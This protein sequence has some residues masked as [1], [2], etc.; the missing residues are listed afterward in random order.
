MDA[1]PH[2]R[3]E[4][5]E[6]VNEKRPRPG[7]GKNPPADPRAHGAGLQDS[8]AQARAAAADEIPGFDNRV[9]FKLQ[10]GTLPPEEIEK[11]FP[12]VE[13][14]SQEDAGQVLAFATAEAL[15]FFEARL[16]TLAAGGKPK[17][18]QVVYALQAFDR[19]TRE[20]RTG[21][22]LRLHGVP[23]APS[24]R[25]DIELWPIERRTER[26]RLLES[27]EAWLTSGNIRVLDRIDQPGLIMFRVEV[28]AA[29][30]GQLLN[31]RD[32]RS[33]DLPPRYGIDRELLGL[34]IATFPPIPAPPANAPLVAVLDSG[35]AGGHPLIG[36]ALADAQGFVLPER[37]HADDH[38][39]GTHVAGIALYGDVE[40]AARARAF[41]PQLRLLS[42]RILDE[43]AQ[44][45]PRFIENIV[46]QAV[47]YFHGEYG[48]RIFNL[49]YGDANKPYLGGR[50]R[51]LA[52]TID[53]LSR[54]LGVLF[55]VPTGNFNDIVDGE[56]PG[57][58][59]TE[60]GRLLD[61]APALN[62]LTVGS[63]ARWDSD[64]YAARYPNDPRH[65]AIAQRDELS[66]FSRGGCSVQSAIKPDL[67]AYGGNFA[68]DRVTGQV[69]GTGL[70]ELSAS[71]EFTE[72]RL[73]SERSGTSFAAPQVAHL[74]A[75]LVGELPD[76]SVN[77]LRALLVANARIPL[78]A[79]SLFDDD[80]AALAETVGYG[81][82]DTSGLF[83]ST[84]EH[85]ILLAEAALR[86]RR[87]HFYQVPV[88]PSLMTSGR[89]TRELTVSLAH[90]P[91]VRT[92]RID[93]CASDI[94]FRVVEGDSLTE[95]ARAFDKA[96]S[97]E[98]YE[99]IGE[100]LT[101]GRRRYGATARSKG[102]V[103]ASTWVIKQPRTKQLFIVVTRNDPAWGATYSSEEEGY[104][105]AI[106]ISDREN[107]HARL[108]SEARAQLR[109][110]ARA[111]VR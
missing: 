44:A 97:K 69:F 57:V 14:I 53:A 56:Y 25:L 78:A 28:T 2:L 79:V 11:G 17:Y 84:E 51:G 66:P 42:G 27:F 81:M 71:R 73:L 23:T 38:G 63:L 76:S 106:R 64:F 24:F 102:T 87:H 39:H 110:R 103:Q 85:V 101:S 18:A 32:V 58:L 68:V 48:C 98:A 93:Y 10:A 86:D 31:H 37:E 7:F 3:L 61:P 75:R 43:A 26:Q 9:L 47:R 60:R 1:Y 111:R 5:E 29:Q 95:V 88:P 19:W 40:E 46:D 34:D 49:S 36:P 80:D 22:A 74:A 6:P 108:Y 33:V 30:T 70:G 82:V 41:V 12:G 77:L 92:T 21:Q 89:R 15:A 99:G 83:R 52:F 94:S 16:A 100:F 91:A 109:A 67:V 62:A 105:L 8:L 4:R 35:V 72:G 107:V 45:D 90:C 54:E 104:A 20:D 55:V 65:A 96:T 50:V 13:V 59:R